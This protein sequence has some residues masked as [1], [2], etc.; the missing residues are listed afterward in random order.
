MHNLSTLSELYA[1]QETGSTIQK[2]LL[3]K[4]IIVFIASVA[5]AVLFDL[6]LRIEHYTREGVQNIPEEL[7]E[8]IRTK[9]LDEFAKY[10]DNAKSKKLLGTDAVF[11]S[12]LH[13]LRKLRNR[14]HIQNS[15]NHFEPD[16]SVAFSRARQITAERTLE[17]LMKIMERDYARVNVGDHVAEFILPWNA[18]I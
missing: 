6:Y 2:K 15:K 8:E 3:R 14:I 12:N 16:D 1:I 5:E 18:H 11:Y 13:D 4:P 7:L 9:I 17:S 10:I